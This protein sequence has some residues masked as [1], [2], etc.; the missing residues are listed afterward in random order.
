MQ[1][2]LYDVSKK[3]VV[4]ARTRSNAFVVFDKF[5][6]LSSKKYRY[7][8]AYIFSLHGPGFS[9]QITTK[10]LFGLEMASHKRPKLDN[11]RLF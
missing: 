5:Q 7:L 1:S 11:T 9:K 4:Y 10:K 3:S 8:Q 6:Q 2:H